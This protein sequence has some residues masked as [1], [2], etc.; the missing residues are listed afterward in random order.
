MSGEFRNG[1][2]SSFRLAEENGREGKQEK[3]KRPEPPW[4][5]DKP[6]P[7][8]LVPCTVYPC[9]LYLVP[10]LL[11]LDHVLERD[12]AVLSGGELQRFAI[13]MVAVQMADVYSAR[14][15]LLVSGF[16]LYLNALLLFFPDLP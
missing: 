13:A 7:P 15:R 1:S 9:A 10:V 14:S 11:Q 4:N 5:D 8:V 6:Q 2:L 12:I 3:E 16:L